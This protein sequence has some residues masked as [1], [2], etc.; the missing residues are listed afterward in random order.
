MLFYY[1]YYLTTPR[2][3]VRTVPIDPGAVEIG[4]TS[5]VAGGAVLTRGTSYQMGDIH[6]TADDVL[7]APRQYPAA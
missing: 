1:Y 3:R 4:L 5:T 6:T 2:A 7:A